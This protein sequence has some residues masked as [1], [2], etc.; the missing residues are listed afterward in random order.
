MAWHRH[1]DVINGVGKNVL[2]QSSIDWLLAE[3]K[4][5]TESFAM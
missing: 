3:G 2:D 1:D 5:H 4:A